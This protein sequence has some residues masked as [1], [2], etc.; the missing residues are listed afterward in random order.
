MEP[1]VWTSRRHGLE[2]NGNIG[3]LVVDVDIDI[4]ELSVGVALTDVSAR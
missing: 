3:Q 1:S 4:D 2:I